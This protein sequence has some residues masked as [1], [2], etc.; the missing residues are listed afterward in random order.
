[1]GL[2]R[3]IISLRTVLASHRAHG[4]LILPSKAST[5]V[6]LVQVVGGKTSESAQACLRLFCLIYMF[7]GVDALSVTYDSTV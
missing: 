3:A 5:V 6:V 7:L 2:S 1:M 4:I